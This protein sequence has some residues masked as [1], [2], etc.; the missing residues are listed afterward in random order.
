MRDRVVNCFGA[1]CHG[2]WVFPCWLGN[3]HNDIWVNYNV[4]ERGLVRSMYLQ[5]SS[6]FTS[7]FL[8][9][10][11]FP[12]QD[13]VATLFKAYHQR[14]KGPAFTEVPA[15]GMIPNLSKTKAIQRELTGSWVE[16]S[17]RFSQASKQ[18]RMYR[19]NPMPSL[20]FNSD[21][22]DQ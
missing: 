9:R 19:K 22:T 16:R 20:Q 17:K 3:V 5:G 11:V 12:C 8:W 13:R 2:V 10:P 15:L 21:V 1:G 4:V 18:M 7:G 14:H 6:C